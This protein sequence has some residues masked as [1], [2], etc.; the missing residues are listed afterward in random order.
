M[1][2]HIGP[3]VLRAT[4]G[5]SDH[6]DGFRIHHFPPK[7]VENGLMFNLDFGDKRCDSGD[8]STT[9]HD[10]SGNGK[11]FTRSGGFA[12]TG[13]AGGVREF[14]GNN[15]HIF[16]NDPELVCGLKKFTIQF[17]FLTENASTRQGLVS[18]HMNYGG[19]HQDAIEI[20]MRDNN[21][22]MTGFRRSPGSA[23]SAVTGATDIST[24]TWY[25]IAMVVDGQS[26]K[27]Y[28][29]GSLIGTTN[30]TVGSVTETPNTNPTLVLGR[31]ASHYLHGYMGYCRMYNRSLSAA[32]ILRNYNATRIRHINTDWTDTFTPTCSGQKGKVEVL[33]VGAGGNGGM[34]VGGGGGGAQVTHDPS[35]TVTSGTSITATVGNHRIHSSGNDQSAGPNHHGANGRSSSFSTLTALGGNGGSGRTGSKSSAGMHGGGGSYSFGAVT[36]PSGGGNAGGATGGAGTNDCGCGG[37]GG[38]GSAGETG[39][40]SAKAGR[41]GDGVVYDISGEPVAY[42]AGGGGSYYSSSGVRGLGGSNTGGDGGGASVGAGPGANN[43]RHGTGSGGGGAHSNGTYN[44]NNGHGGH[45][46]VIVRYPAEEYEVEVLVVAGGGG[47]GKSGAAGSDPAGGGGGGGGVVFKSAHKVLSGKNY[48]VN[49]GNGGAG[50]SSNSAYSH[51]PNGVN[52]VFDDIIA[53]GGGA[54]GHGN[55]KGLTGGSGGGG[56]GNSGEKA[57]GTP[58]QGNDGGDPH[59]DGGGGGGGAGAA[60]TNAG[61]GGSGHGGAGKAYTISGSSVTYAG[62][63]GGGAR[64][65]NTVGNGGAGGGGGGMIGSSGQ[66]GETSTGGGGGGTSTGTQGGD[67]GSGIVIVAYK[68][69]QR[70]EGGT[71]STTA[72]SGYTTHTFT[73]Y[74]DDTYIA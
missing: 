20:E 67:G 40:T 23:F 18:S 39:T 33:V 30:Y 74:G 35:L 63:G 9:Y 3:R 16:R 25:D 55:A 49:V 51:A 26:I 66:N 47:G 62:G 44:Y 42:G 29:N 19:T 28:R 60:G 22:L 59:S 10:L 11:N 58:Q 24:N 7:I 54:G 17:N 48:H 68:G 32:E 46:T 1:G 64:L 72:R 71:V 38:A 36:S 14:D 56:G 53:I 73:N 27:Q 52:S 50:T 70:G 12:F 61:E 31:Y 4:G 37:G 15:D 34:D 8:A 43:G 57:S 69:P 6:K 2:F 45:G 5:S 41:G 21:S 65:G 13:F